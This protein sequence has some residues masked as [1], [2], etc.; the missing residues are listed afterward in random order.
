MNRQ[1]FTLIE[2]LAALLIMAIGGVA[3]LGMV[4][5]AV[6]LSS[7]GQSG[8]TALRTALTVVDDAEPLG[9]TADIGDADQDGWGSDR[10]L[11]GLLSSGDYD[12]F[13]VQGVI[14]GYWV[15]RAESSTA[16]DRISASQRMA[17]VTVDVFWSNDDRFVTAVRRRILR[18]GAMP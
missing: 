8:L 1:A 12:G 6:R 17:T 11:S 16:A 18:Q 10:A 9:L 5:Y 7:E 15:R 3:V 2:A 13:T 4:T 14:N